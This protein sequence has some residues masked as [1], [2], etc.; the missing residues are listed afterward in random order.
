VFLIIDALDYGFQVACNAYEGEDKLSLDSLIDIIDFQQ[1]DGEKEIRQEESDGSTGNSE[2]TI[3]VVG[4]DNKK[5]LAPT[6]SLQT[7]RVEI[8][9]DDEDAESGNDE[10]EKE[11]DAIEKEMEGMT[12]MGS[13][14]RSTLAVPKLQRGSSIRVKKEAF[15]SIVESCCPIIAMDKKPR[16]KEFARLDF[17]HSNFFNGKLDQVTVGGQTTRKGSMTM[18][19]SKTGSRLWTSEKQK[20]E[21]REELLFLLEKVHFGSGGLDISFSVHNSTGKAINFE[22]GV[23]KLWQSWSVEKFFLIADRA[24]PARSQHGAGGKAG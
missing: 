19:P 8:N 20:I 21:R 16:F 22:V 24:A 9:D 6:N 7:D 23:G 10:F 18:V 14:A 12:R 5:K 13:G 15:K 17:S 3:E 11:L 1:I 2:V 4:P